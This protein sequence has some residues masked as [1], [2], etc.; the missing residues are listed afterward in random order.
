MKMQRLNL[1]GFLCP[2]RQAGQEEEDGGACYQLH[3]G[4]SNTGLEL[5]SLPD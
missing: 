5:F 2:G 4:Y 3:A 1:R